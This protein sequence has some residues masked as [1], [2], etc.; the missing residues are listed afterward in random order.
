MIRFFV[1]DFLVFAETFWERTLM[2]RLT[3]STWCCVNMNFREGC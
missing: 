3:A 2:L 1:L